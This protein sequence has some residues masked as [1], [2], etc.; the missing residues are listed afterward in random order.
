MQP[1]SAAIET[2]SNIEIKKTTE[3]TEVTEKIN[4]GY[5]QIDTD[6]YTI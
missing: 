2:N 4:R 6:N 5:T 1:K 3:N